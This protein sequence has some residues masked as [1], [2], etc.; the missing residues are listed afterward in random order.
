MKQDGNQ[1]PSST[2]GFHLSQ[3]NVLPQGLTRPLGPYLKVSSL[4]TL[5]ESGKNLHTKT[6]SPDSDELRSGSVWDEGVTSWRLIHGA[7]SLRFKVPRSSNPPDGRSGRPLSY[8]VLGS[9]KTIGDSS[10]NRTSHYGNPSV[11]REG[12]RKDFDKELD[13][14]VVFGLR[15]VN[16]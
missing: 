15:I 9:K 16:W 1:T 8:S 12:E 2:T 5:T 4:W 13:S 6:G 7:S 10:T 14:G 3:T 11:H